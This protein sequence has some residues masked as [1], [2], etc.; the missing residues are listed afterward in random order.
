MPGKNTAIRD[1]RLRKTL[2]REVVTEIDAVTH[3]LVGNAVGKLLVEAKF[4]VK[5]G[6]ERPER[7][8]HQPCAPVGILFADH[9]YFRAAAPAR[10]VIVPFNLVLGDFAENTR[11]DEVAH[12]NLVRFAAM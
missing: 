5:L 2:V 11:T 9:L 12:S 6:I 4:K 10:P 7:L 8:G 3:P 1:D